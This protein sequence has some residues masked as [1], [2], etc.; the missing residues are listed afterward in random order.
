MQPDPGVFYSGFEITFFVLKY[1]IC[2][3][4]VFN[5]YFM[6]NIINIIKVNMKIVLIRLP[7]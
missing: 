4:D 6:Q 3:F 1:Q 7:C 2:R 5:I